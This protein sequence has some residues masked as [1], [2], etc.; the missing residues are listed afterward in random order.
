M[1]TLSFTADLEL[2]E[3][4]M[5]LAMSGW[6]DA[7]SVGT[8]TAERI[9][10]DGDVVA[11]FDPDALFDYRSSRPVLHFTAGRLEKIVWPRLEVVHRVIEGRDLLVVLGSEPDFRWREFTGDMV[12]LAERYGVTKLVTLGAV[13][14]P[15]PHTRPIRILCT[16]SD[17]DLLL[18]EDL[19]LPEDLVVPGA[20]VSIVR[21]GLADAGIPAIGYWAQIPHYLQSPFSPGVMGLLER[22]G[23][24]VGVTFPAG[25]LA[26]EAAAQILEISSDLAERE[27]AVAYVERLERIY[28]EDDP[29]GEGLGDA[30]VI[31]MDDIPTIE[32]IGV[33][34]E[35]FLR[36]A[37]DE[38]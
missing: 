25:D 23:A 37:T 24:Q 33:E 26:T 7:A 28:D 6:V 2:D 31:S 36:S 11:R 38:G 27:D 9:A 22:V 3:P 4:I 15:T 8:G 35:K 21:Q 13:P 30:P 10:G 16:T 5:L 12:D 14:A 34:I 19:V 29:S 18:E 32:E 20:A 17:S 1:T